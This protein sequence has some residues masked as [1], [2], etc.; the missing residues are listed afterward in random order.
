LLARA[1]KGYAEI[2]ILCE[3]AYMDLALQKTLILAILKKV[4]WGKTT[5][6]QRHLSLQ[7]MKRIDDINAAV[8]AAVK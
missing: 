6:N 5:K 8:T 4:K 2:K 3:A 7:K 1:S